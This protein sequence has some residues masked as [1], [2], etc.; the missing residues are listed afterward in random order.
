MTKGAGGSR[1][2]SSP[3]A[4]GHDQPSA[5]P[6]SSAPTVLPVEPDD[7]IGSLREKLDLAES[8]RVVLVV[9]RSARLFRNP[10]RLKLLRRYARQ[11]AREVAIVAE[12]GEVRRLARAEG[13]RVARSVEAVSFA[14]G[15]RSLALPAISPAGLIAGGALLALILLACST[16]SALLVPSATVEIAPVATPVTEV[17]TVRASRQARGVNADQRTVSARLVTA[18]AEASDTTEA[19]GR[20]SAPTERA[21]ARVTITNR[22]PQD[23]Q[24]TLP[25]GTLVRTLGNIQFALDDAVVVPASPAPVQVG[26]TAVEPGVSGNVAARAITAFSDPALNTRA[27]VVNEQPATGGAQSETPF[28]TL[29]DRNRLRQTVIEKLRAAGYAQLYDTKRPNESIYRETVQVTVVEETFDRLLDEEAS[30]VTI[31]ARARVSAI[32]FTSDD[33]LELGQRVA[34][35]QVPPGQQILPGSLTVAPLGLVGADDDAVSFNLSV[36][37]LAIPQIDEAQIKSAIA[38]QPVGQ[39]ERYL[40]STL[41]LRRPPTISVWPGGLPWLPRLTQRLELRIVGS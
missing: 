36:T 5:G 28:V 7:D 2:S 37:Y 34:R 6:L 24:F 4:L 22:N 35:A 23:G 10:V 27:T 17:L 13:F 20:K 29:A 40:A 16:A 12:D 26:V 18:E 25:R 32:A 11:V 30:T 19:T 9:P 15:A 21:K 41:Q 31:R 3:Y 39:A 8:R 33:V 14:P 1:G 38:G